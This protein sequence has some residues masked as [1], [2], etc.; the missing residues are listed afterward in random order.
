MRLS[1][2]LYI[3]FGGKPPKPQVVKPKNRKLSD[4]K[5]GEFI[6]VEYFKALDKIIS[7]KVLNNDPDKK[8]MLIEF[9]WK[10]EGLGRKVFSYC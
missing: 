6:T 8:R 2:W 3:F 7:V 10:G 4:V 1:E 9:N 5:A